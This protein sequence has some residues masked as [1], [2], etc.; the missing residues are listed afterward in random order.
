VDALLAQ[1]R[2]QFTASLP[3][4]VAALQQLVARGVWEEARRAAHK[5]RGSA[6]TYGHTALGATAGAIEEALL[7]TS[8]QPD[9][10]ARAGIAA[11]LA[12]AHAQA[13]QAT[14]GV[15]DAE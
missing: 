8:D 7:A 2:A 10:E 4:K 13:A 11:R 6:S 1:V 3:S 15:G 12:E 9:E 14:R 5:L